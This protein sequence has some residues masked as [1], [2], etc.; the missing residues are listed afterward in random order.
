MQ[1]LKQALTNSPVF[2]NPDFSLPFTVHTDA[3]EA[4]LGAILSQNFNSKEHSVLY[5][6]R[7]LTPTEWKYDTVEREALTIKWA[8]EE[9]RYY[10]VRRHFTL[11][12]DHAP[13]QW[14]AQAKDTN[15]RVTR[16]CFLLQEFLFQVHHWGPTW[17]H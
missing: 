3:S 5:V 16:W 9:M 17:K 8:V 14:I 7:K 10:L 4:G 6:S 2:R 11:V 1:A 15:T 12:T 13:L